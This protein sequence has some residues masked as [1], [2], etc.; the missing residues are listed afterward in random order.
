MFLEVGG[1][2]ETEVLLCQVY[3]RSVPLGDPLPIYLL[4]Q[5]GFLIPLGQLARLLDL[6]VDVD[7]NQRIVRG[8]L[9]SPEDTFTWDFRT[10]EVRRGGVLL[11][12]IAGAVELHPDDVYVTAEQLE[13]W[14]PLK[15][16]V[17]PKSASITVIPTVLLPVEAARDRALRGQGMRIRTDKG[18]D[19]PLEIPAYSAFD[20]GAADFNLS[21]GRSQHGVG[22]GTQ[23]SAA[24]AGDMLWMNGYLRM[25]RYADRWSKLHG[26]LERRDPGGG[27]L[28]PLKAQ[29][30]AIGDVYA[31][32]VDLVSGGLFGYGAM[33]TNRDPRGSLRDNLRTFDGLLPSGWQIEIYVNGQLRGFQDSG[34][35]GRFEFKDVALNYG[36]N[37][38]ELVYYGPQGERRRENS[39][40]NT[41]DLVAGAGEFK[42][43]AGVSRPENYQGRGQIEGIYGLSREWNLIAGAALMHMGPTGSAISLPNEPTSAR[44]FGSVSLQGQWK[45][46]G[47]LFSGAS[48]DRGGKAGSAFVQTQVKGWSIGLRESLLD[49]FTS[50][51]FQSQMGPLK[52]RTN[53]DLGGPLIQGKLMNMGANLNLRRDRLEGG[54]DLDTARLGLSASIV[55]WY[56]TNT[57]SSFKDSRQTEAIPIMGSLAFTRPIGKW[58]MRGDASYT[59]GK[60]RELDSLSLGLDS[61]QLHGVRFSSGVTRAVR[62]GETGGFTSVQ[63]VEGKFSFGATASYS[64]SSGVSISAT[65]HIGFSRNPLT[66]AW[67]PQASSAT[68]QSLVATRAYLDTHGEKPGAPGTKGLAGTVFRAN[69]GVNESIADLQGRGVIPGIGAWNEV[70]ISAAPPESDDNRIIRISN[71]VRRIYTRPGKSMI[72]DYRAQ[73]MAEITGTVFIKELGPALG[74]GGLHVELVDASGQVLQTTRT[75]F[76]GFFE[77]KDVPSGARYILRL[78][79]ADVRALSLSRFLAEKAPDSARSEDRSSLEREVIVPAEGGFLDGRDLVGVLP[80]AAAP[81]LRAGDPSVEGPVI[82]VR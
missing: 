65:F 22:P 3:L 40:I 82:A 36:M 75:A 69:A 59:L 60:I 73:L 68:S 61:G 29:Q 2:S 35:T 80:K 10:G 67:L 70:R 23:G 63:R 39:R 37:E 45:G 79:G 54:G 62:T 4:G 49:N 18:K 46:V 56:F 41:Q 81:T 42:Y 28:G 12:V 16:R 44:S 38:I 31:P 27:L 7:V 6:P 55:G 26:V 52:R 51:T 30:V 21:G 74:R 48:D 58:V 15:V 72:V 57:L 32:G 43:L 76:D 14:W 71:E 66:H 64:R 1:R 20:I 77:F 17:D 34:A 47:L 19:L 25:D 8:F 53:L 50:E 24:I 5:K 78:T 11:P 33:I 9:T 13:A